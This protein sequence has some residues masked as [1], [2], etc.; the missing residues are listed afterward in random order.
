MGNKIDLTGQS[1]NE[2][3]VLGESGLTGSGGIKWL[4]ICS[5]GTERSIPS[6]ALRSGKSRSCGCIKRIGAEDMIGLKFRRL[7]VIDVADSDGD[8]KQFLCRCDCGNEVVVRSGNLRSGNSGS[9][10]CGKGATHGMSH[11]SEY[12][13]WSSMKERCLNPKNKAY[14]YYGGRGIGIQ[15]DWIRDFVAFFE[16]VGPRPGPEYSLDRIDSDG[17]YES[18]NVRWA[19]PQ[20]QWDNRKVRSLSFETYQHQT[21]ETAIY[22]REVEQEALVYC[23]LGLISEAGEVGGKVKKLIRDKNFNISI[24][25]KKQIISEMGDVL[26]YLSELSNTL[27]ISLAEVAKSNIAKLMDRLERNVIHGDGDNR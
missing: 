1:F 17:N 22:P 10:G 25:D 21:K 14:R 19:T 8:Q 4:C 13:I 24:E 27:N 16:S 20:E 11:Y 23:S 18:G 7:L 5:C 12:G 26:W 9:C 2:W 3:T 6:D 15:E